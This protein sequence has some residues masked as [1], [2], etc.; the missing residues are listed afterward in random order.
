[1]MSNTS[2][3]PGPSGISMSSSNPGGNLGHVN[4]VPGGVPG[5]GVLGASPS[6]GNVGGVN[7]GGPTGSASG[8]GTGMGGSVGGASGSGTG[9]MSSPT[10]KKRKQGSDEASA[11]TANADHPN[12]RLTR[13]KPR[14]GRIGGG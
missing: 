7:A 8:L 12:K 6:M 5:V 1:M 11:T 10:P 3:T 2:L 13:T 9:A 14:G 4:G